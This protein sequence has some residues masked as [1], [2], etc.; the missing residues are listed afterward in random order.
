MKTILFP[1]LL[2]LL[3]FTTSFSQKTNQKQ[4]ANSNNQKQ[5]AL[6]F[7]GFKSTGNLKNELTSEEIKVFYDLIIADSSIT[8]IQ[9]D[10][11]HPGNELAPLVK[12][13]SKETKST[14]LKTAQ[15]T[16]GPKSC[17]I[18]QGKKL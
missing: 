2:S 3:F 13:L 15:F 8:Q 16:E 10:F 18:K 6:Y 9:Y 7:R 12:K 17:S 14:L 5:G 4:T 1:F 11:E